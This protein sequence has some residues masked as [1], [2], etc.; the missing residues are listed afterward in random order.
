MRT[1]QTL[2]L[3]TVLALTTLGFVLVVVL[4]I[5]ARFRP[6]TLGRTRLLSLGFYL[7]G[8]GFFFFAA[9]G[10]YFIR[11][12]DRITVEG[13][14]QNLRQGPGTNRASY[15]VIAY[16]QPPQLSPR[17]SADYSGPRLA[18]GEQVRVTYLSNT[19]TVTD[20]RVLAGPNSGFTIHERDGTRTNVFLMAMA[21]V[22]LFIGYYSRPKRAHSRSKHT[23]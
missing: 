21:C 14:V 23:L 4:T 18:D 5:W 3:F 1:Y 13:S 9:A 10:M 7:A 16:G 6:P 11:S 17:L 20:L 12:S 2:G 22:F 8:G 15:F 19:T